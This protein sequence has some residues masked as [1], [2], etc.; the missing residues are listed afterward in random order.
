[1]VVKGV[2]LFI[3]FPVLVE[4][5]HTLLIPILLLCSPLLAL[6]GGDSETVVT[7]LSVASMVVAVIGAGIITYGLWPDRGSN[8]EGAPGRHGVS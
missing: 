4:V 1:M 5:I 2:I 3:V 7:I 8:D 6:V